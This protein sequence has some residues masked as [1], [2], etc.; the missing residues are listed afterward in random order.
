MVSY[1]SFMNSQQKMVVWKEVSNGVNGVKGT[2]LRD[3]LSIKETNDSSLFD[4]LG[5]GCRENEASPKE[6]KTLHVSGFVQWYAMSRE[7]IDAYPGSKEC[8]F[9]GEE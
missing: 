2:N 9:E 8:L 5:A 1:S 7:L 3:W 6:E 4:F